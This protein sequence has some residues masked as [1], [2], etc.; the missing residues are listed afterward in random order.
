[1]PDPLTV[2]IQPPAGDTTGAELPIGAAHDL[3]DSPGPLPRLV[4][5]AAVARGIAATARLLARRR[6][7]MPTEHIGRTLHFAD[8][9][10][11][12]VSRETTV[13][14]APGDDVGD[15]CV[16]VVT[17]RLR[18]VRGRLGHGAF[19]WESLL[20]TPLIVGFPGFVSKLWLA[21]DRH[22]AYRGLY[23]WDDP[24]LA[25]RYARCLW[26]VLALV[27][28]RGTIRYEVLPGLRRDQV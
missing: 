4:A 9:T 3:Q 21:H 12:R 28:V 20:N 22:G 17:F 6:I 7:H 11:A 24:A 26:P 14:R 19:R 15:P 2:E 8:D 10:A 27:S 1:M 5:A 23:E 13:E 16:L 18:W 25:E